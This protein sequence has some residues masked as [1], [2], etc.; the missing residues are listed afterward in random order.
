MYQY[1]L[2]VRPIYTAQQSRANN[3]ELCSQ[4]TTTDPW[5][6]AHTGIRERADGHPRRRT[7]SAPL[8]IM[9]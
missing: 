7:T 2:K 4:P 3:L 5:P 1:L 6:R 9:T 8:D